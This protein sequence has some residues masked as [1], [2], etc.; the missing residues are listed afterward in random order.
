[1]LQV[2]ISFIHLKTL[3]LAQYWY[4]Y[5]R[6]IVSDLYSK[7][8][9]VRKCLKI[10]FYIIVILFIFITYMYVLTILPI[11]IMLSMYSVKWKIYKNIKQVG[12]AGCV[13]VFAFA[14][15]RSDPSQDG[16]VS[17]TLVQPT[18]MVAWPHQPGMLKE[19]KPYASHIT[20]VV[21]STPNST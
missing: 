18:Q 13:M 6:N 14:F 9:V 19:V 4:S 3:E 7:L 17:K 10:Y 5:H 15:K 2:L 12:S 20:V 1:M 16:W 21:Y 11:C 8:V